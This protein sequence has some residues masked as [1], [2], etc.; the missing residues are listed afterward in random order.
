MPSPGMWST[1]LLGMQRLWVAEMVMH[2]HL[3]L[4]HL[5]PER[6]QRVPKRSSEMP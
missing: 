2:P 4:V 5:E 1:L 6:I 3:S